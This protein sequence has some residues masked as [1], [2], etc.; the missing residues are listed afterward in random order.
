MN[1][2]IG[3]CFRFYVDHFSDMEALYNLGYLP[4]AS[5]PQEK[6]KKVRDVIN[7]ASSQA[8]SLLRSGATEFI[9]SLNL[10]G[11]R[12][13]APQNQRNTLTRDWNLRIYLYSSD[14]NAFAEAGLAINVPQNGR[15]ELCLWI[16]SWSKSKA[17]QREVIHTLQDKGIK[18]ARAADAKH[19]P[20]HYVLIDSLEL[21]VDVGVNDCMQWVTQITQQTLIPSWNE[22]H[23]TLT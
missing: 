3:Q 5:V 18:T 17:I 7:K 10:R 20:A 6:W 22:L 13:A 4:P 9:K 12:Y 8:T 1:V 2:S 21:A 15:A 14:Y 16:A 19:W 23:L 11:V